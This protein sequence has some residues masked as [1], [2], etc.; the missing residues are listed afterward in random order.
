MSADEDWQERTTTA[1]GGMPTRPPRWL[2]ESV[3]RLEESRALDPVADRVGAVAA[4]AAKGR[5]GDVLH[6]KWLGHALHPL[7][8]DL[9]LGCWLSASLLD[10]LG[11]RGSRT[12]AR[13]LVGLGLLFV[14]P[15][16]AAGLADYPTSDQVRNRR[17]ATV[18]AA[19]NVVM[20]GMYLLSWRARRRNHHLRGVLWALAGGGLAWATGYLGGHLSFSRGVG[21]GARGLAPARPA[22]PISGPVIRPPEVRAVR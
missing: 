8:T 14:P 6:G 7:L 21:T 13:R 20:S 5:V 18:H 12:A 3:E 2:R 10:L 1:W 11:G 17:V 9:P 4:P 16:V 15:T 22:A 19:G